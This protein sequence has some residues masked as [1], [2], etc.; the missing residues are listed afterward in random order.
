MLLKREVWSSSVFTFR[1]TTLD[2]VRPDYL[3]GITALTT[4]SAPQVKEVVKRVWDSQDVTT[5]IESL[6]DAIPDDQKTAAKENLTKFTESLQVKAMNIKKQGGAAAPTFNIYANANFI[7]DDGLWC[8]LRNYL[9]SQSYALLFQDPGSAGTDLHRCSICH[10]IEHPRGLCPFPGIKGW[11]GPLW[12]LKLPDTK[13]DDN[14]KFRS[15]KPKRGT[16]R[17]F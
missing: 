15:A 9:A 4:Q 2:P 7:N 13:R 12:D 3:F 14:W 6:T 10:S 11:N 17:P 8:L 5:F 16:G 1:V